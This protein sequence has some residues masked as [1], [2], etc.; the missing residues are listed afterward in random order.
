MK[1]PVSRR[2]FLIAG[3]VG[4]AGAM[5]VLPSLADE[6]RRNAASS[7]AASA[8][9]ICVALCSHWSYTGIGWNMGIE[10]CVQSIEDVMGMADRPPYVKACANFDA[11]AYRIHGRN[12]PRSHGSTETAPGRRKGRTDRRHLRP[13]DGHDVRRRIEHPPTGCRPRDDPPGARLR[14]G[15]FFGGRGVHASAGSANRRRRQA[16]ATPVWRRPIRGAGRAFPSKSSTSF[17]GAAS[18]ARRS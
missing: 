5:F 17:I 16:I 2:D 13:A 4:G 18:T 7:A 1:K 10:S 9:G 11:R 6:S 8:E 12:I 3:M 14:N 15:H